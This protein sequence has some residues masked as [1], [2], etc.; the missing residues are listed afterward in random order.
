MALALTSAIERFEQD[1]LSLMEEVPQPSVIS[2]NTIVLAAASQLCG[3]PFEQ[4]PPWKSTIVATPHGE[5]GERRP[6]FPRR[7]APFQ[8]RSPPT[9]QPPA[10]FE[11]EKLKGLAVSPRVPAEAQQPGLVLRQA[12]AVLAEPLAQRRVETPRIRLVLERRYKIIGITAKIR[13]TATMGLHHLF[14]PLV[15]H[16]MQIDVRQNR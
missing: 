12:Q 3:H 1:T 2:T 4:F 9:A 13:R 6:V 11:A 8:D 7:R 14:M 10:E 15:Q 16:L 5:V